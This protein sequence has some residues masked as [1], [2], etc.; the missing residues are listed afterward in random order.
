VDIDAAKAAAAIRSGHLLPNERRKVKGL[1]RSKT[2]PSKRPKYGPDD[3]LQV[4][5]VNR[6][7]SVRERRPEEIP[8]L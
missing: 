7:S 3:P 5:H 8:E 6:G 2:V 1:A 4:V